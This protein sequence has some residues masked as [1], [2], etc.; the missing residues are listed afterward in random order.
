M[1]GR[2][3]LDRLIARPDFADFNAPKLMPPRALR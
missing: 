2:M 1:A 3:L